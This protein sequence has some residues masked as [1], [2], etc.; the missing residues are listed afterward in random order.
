M[1]QIKSSALFVSRACGSEIC[2]GRFCRSLARTCD[3]RDC[4]LNT[5]TSWSCCAINNPRRS[6]HTDSTTLLV[7]LDWPPSPCPL[8]ACCWPDCDNLKSLFIVVAHWEEVGANSFR[9]RLV[10]LDT[11]FV[12]CPMHLSSALWWKCCRF[13]LCFTQDWT[14]HVLLTHSRRAELKSSPE[15]NLTANRPERAIRLYQS[16]ALNVLALLSTLWRRRGNSLEASLSFEKVPQKCKKI[17]QFEIWFAEWMF[18]SSAKGA[19][20]LN[21]FSPL[22]S[23]H[24]SWTA[25]RTAWK[26]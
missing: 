4:S 8:K 2:C 20:I 5:R 23:S 22:K 15:N 11:C 25:L 6:A 19:D 7:P 9:F 16:H 12:L 26:M 18:G 14:L 17:S 13:V 3:S 10:F 1:K 21:Q 24:V